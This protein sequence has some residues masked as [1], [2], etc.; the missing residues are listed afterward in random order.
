M[1]RNLAVDVLR[2]VSAFMVVLFHSNYFCKDIVNIIP[3]YAVP[4]FFMISGFF[5]FE[6]DDQRFKERLNR[7]IKKMIVLTLVDSFFFFLFYLPL[8]L[9]D[10]FPPLSAYLKFI[11]FNENPFA[12]HLW[13]LTAFLYVLLLFRALVGTHILKVIIRYSPFLLLINLLLGEFGFLFWD[14]SLPNCVL[15]NF[16]LEGLPFY[17]IG[18]LISINKEKLQMS[19]R[20]FSS[21]LMTVV[22]FSL[23]EY[24]HIKYWGSVEMATT[25]DL[26]IS[27]ILFSVVILIWAIQPHSMNRI[28]EKMAEWGQKY[29]L[30]IYI[31][32][33]AFLVII[34]SAL[35]N[36]E[37]VLNAYSS[38]F[39]PI[40]VFFCTLA[41]AIVWR[42]IKQRIP[43]LNK[44]L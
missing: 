6:A 20:M 33:V 24:Y 17:S 35:K 41:F 15:R 19:G 14:D 40:V 21:A 23:M 32:H 29:S 8:Y 16:L 31:F 22:A 9:R 42:Q 37:D 30:D 11:V 43:L 13:Y 7:S 27:S 28:G 36:N 18:C 44:Y 34:R 5:M 2:F 4:V 26:F 38:F 10:G 12:F 39:E 1:K 25:T 3:R